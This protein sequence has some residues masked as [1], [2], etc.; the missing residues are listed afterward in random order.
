MSA[1][2]LNCDFDSVDRAIV[3]ATQAGLPLVSR[4]YHAVAATIGIAPTDVIRRVQRMLDAGII[5]RVGIVPNHYVLGMVHNAMTVWDVADDDIT[6]LGR[7]IGALEFVTHCYH[8]PRCLP[9]WPYN[10]FAMVHGATEDELTTKTA[11][12]TELL[13]AACRGRDV[14]ISKRILKKAGLRISA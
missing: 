10:L 14:L 5:R 12:I 11:V 2:D 3:V 9:V 1:S 13:G 7:I 4:P 8:R 6:R